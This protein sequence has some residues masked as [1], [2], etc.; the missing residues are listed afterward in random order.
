MA[1]TA[2]AAGKAP[3]SQS[4]SIARAKDW[5]LHIFY[6]VKGEYVPM[7]DAEDMAEVQL[8]FNITPE[9]TPSIP[10]EYTTGVQ[11]YINTDDPDSVPWTGYYATY[12]GAHLAVANTSGVWFEI[13]RQPKGWRAVCLV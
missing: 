7:P 6:E 5:R 9:M 13:E 10:D 11:H 12:C 8:P 2:T 1:T 3:C 4:T